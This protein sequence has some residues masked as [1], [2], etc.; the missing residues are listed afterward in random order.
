[1]NKTKR[2]KNEQYSSL[3]DEQDEKAKYYYR[4]CGKKKGYANKN[5]AKYIAAIQRKE[6]EEDIQ[7]YKCT[8]GRHYHIGHPRHIKGEQYG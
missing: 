2:L 4:S 7:A 3:S 1:M 6:T 5:V 8:F